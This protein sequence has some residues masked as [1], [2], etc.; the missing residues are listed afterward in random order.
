MD[1][2]NGDKRGPWQHGR[3]RAAPVFGNSL[4]LVAAALA[5]IQP[6]HLPFRDSSAPPE[7]PVRNGAEQR[8]AE[9]FDLAHTAAFMITSSSACSPTMNL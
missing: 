5:D 6:P 7:E 8:R 2:V 1:L 4:G 3:D 9:D